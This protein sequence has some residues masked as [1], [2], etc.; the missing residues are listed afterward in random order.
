MGNIKARL[1]DSFSSK[2]PKRIIMLGLDGS[3]KTTILYKLKVGEIV[4]IPIIGLQIETIVLENPQ[5]T[6]WDVGSQK[7]IKDLRKHNLLN[8]DA[9]IY[10]LDSSDE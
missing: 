3:G 4:K 2:N 9:I 7:K 10:V 1:L 8:Y 5:W 6:I